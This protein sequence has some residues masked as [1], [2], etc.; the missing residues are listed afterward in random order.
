MLS[1]GSLLLLVDGAACS[2]VNEMSF[3]AYSRVQALP[4][5]VVTLLFFAGFLMRSSSMPR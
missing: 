1:A 5:Y 4:A 3:C 2:R